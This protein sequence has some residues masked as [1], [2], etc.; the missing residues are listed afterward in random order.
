[1]VKSMVDQIKRCYS[2]NRTCEKIVHLALTSFTGQS[3]QEF[4]KRANGFELW[5][6]FTIHE[7]GLEEVWPSEEISGKQHL[8]ELKRL[9]A[10]ASAK[11]EA[12]KAKV[13]AT[14]AQTESASSSASTLAPLPIATGAEEGGVNEKNSSEALLSSASTTESGLGALSEV[15]IQ[16]AVEKQD[17]ISAKEAEASP[18][19]D[20]TYTSPLSTPGTPA[21]LENGT[22]TNPALDIKALEK[23]RQQKEEKLATIPAVKKVVYL[24]ADSPNTITQ[25][26]EN[27]CYVLGG[28]VDKNRYP[29]LCQNKAEKLGIETAQLPIG[30]Y[31]QMSSR[32]I[33]TV[34]QVFEILLQ[35]I[36]CNDWKEAF[37]KVIPQR[38]LEEK[39]R[40]RRSVESW[41]PNHHARDEQLSGFDSRESRSG[42]EA[43]SITS[44]HESEDEGGWGR[45]GEVQDQPMDTDEFKKRSDSV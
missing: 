31:I 35:F 17:N 3:K 6:N 12:V 8:A 26:E 22:T 25:L 29:N 34:N 33:L 28:I 42:S 11:S 45:E 24:S 39:P 15:A 44:S 38:K 30:D 13:L 14:Y 21:T 10:I 19:V 20:Q 1:E 23:E 41:R 37:L 9:Q 2:Y 18:F 32:R 16:N 40:V 4:C 43:R 7:K 27:T 5:K 36:E